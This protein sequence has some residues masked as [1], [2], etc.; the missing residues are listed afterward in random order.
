DLILF[1]V[2]FPLQMESLLTISLLAVIVGCVKVGSFAYKCCN[3]KNAI[4]A[5]LLPFT[6]GLLLPE[7]NK[8]MK[9]VIDIKQYTNTIIN[10]LW[11][12]MAPMTKYIDPLRY[13]RYP[14][15]LI[16]IFEFG[17]DMSFNQ[18]G[19]LKQTDNM[20]SNV[21][22]YG[23][24]TRQQTLELI[25]VFND[26]IEFDFIYDIYILEEWNYIDV[27]QGIKS[28]IIKPRV[29]FQV[30]FHFIHLHIAKLKPTNKKYI[31][32]TDRWKVPMSLN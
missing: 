7:M 10:F 6:K 13:E 4:I 30:Y 2:T 15:T 12:F 27:C 18:S 17:S 14:D 22:W 5:L 1:H 24:A 3:Q 16:I 23:M 26:S 8:K 31:I 29:F 25:K 9:R 21:V 20:D 11:I 28:D 32:A 19:H